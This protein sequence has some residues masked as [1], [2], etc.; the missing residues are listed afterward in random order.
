MT[1][2]EKIKHARIQNNLSQEELANKLCLSRSAIAKWENNKGMPDIM[3]LKALAELFQVSVDYLVDDTAN[4]DTVIM[5]ESIDLTKYGKGLK[6]AKK[7]RVMREKFPNAEIYTLLGKQKYTKTETTVDFLLA[8]FTAAPLGIPEFINSM[9]H[10]DHEFYLVKENNRNYIVVVTQKFVEK[11]E[12]DVDISGKK[13]K[14]DNWVFTNC[15]LIQY[16]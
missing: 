11:R 14:I 6:K 5:K 13:F 12:I 4:V 7:D 15:G 3:N 2:G 1:L 9:K 16:K 10:L 8:F